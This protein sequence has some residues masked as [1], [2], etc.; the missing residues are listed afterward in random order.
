MPI[1]PECAADY[2]ASE[3][4]CR[5]DGATLLPTTDPM[6]GVTV[7]SYRLVK[8]LGEGGMGQVYLGVH[9]NI[10]SRVAVKL[11]APHATR[12]QELV[13]R[14]F[15]E[16]MAVNRIRHE[17]IVNVLDFNAVTL[18]DGSSRPYLVM[19]HLDGRPL[20]AVFAH[21]QRLPQ[22]TL[23]HLIGEVLGALSAAHHAGII[24]RDLKPDNIFV[25]PRGH[26][27]VLD[28]GIAKL[29]PNAAGDGARFTQ[30]GALLGT[31]SYMAPEQVRGEAV[32]AALDLYAVGII[33]FEGLTGS[34][35]F[36][37]E[38]LYALLNQHLTA[39]PPPMRTLTPTIDPRLEAVVLRALAKDP[40]QRF[41]SADAMAHALMAAV[42]QLPPSEWVSISLAG[43][44]PLL[45]NNPIV[46]S[47]PSPMRPD[48]H[49]R[50]GAVDRGSSSRR[51]GIAALAIAGV[52]SI[53]V[54]GLWL[55]R[56]SWVNQGERTASMP[57]VNAPKAEEELR[58]I[59]AMNSNDSIARTETESAESNAGGPS[60]VESSTPQAD[61]EPIELSDE[62]EPPASSET[63]KTPSSGTRSR[64]SDDGRST[65]GRR[66]TPRSDSN[67]T[68]AAA[69]PS[70]P[71]ATKDETKPHS[72]S[73][74]QIVSTAEIAKAEG[75][76][77]ITQAAGVD[78]RRFNAVGY[79]A[80]AKELARRLMSDAQLVE[81]EVSGVKANGVADL[82]QR[83]AEASFWFRSKSRSKPDPALPQGVSPDDIY[84]MVYVDVQGGEAHAYATT[85]E[86]CNDGFERPPRCS[87]AQVWTKAYAMG[88]PRGNWV[89]KLTYNG[90][91]W[92]FDIENGAGDGDDFVATIPD[93]C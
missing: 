48:V 20:S 22:G 80:K 12:N 10:G 8:L 21:F 34:L 28:F 47:T 33:L 50:V 11:I 65:S 63:M 9:P 5:T 23:V 15:A 25:S 41:G 32:T 30:T 16:A 35:P 2:P 87:L 93:N 86:R 71:E 76:K 57:T 29:L 70:E 62:D 45:T 74:V 17:N 24:H 73:G 4:F 53:S 77:P 56:P 84:C 52:A 61:D 68:R 85:R 26:A 55:G 6:I 27:K 83:Y 46:R 69:K 82:N 51:V 49:D 91:E 72:S 54:A 88:A 58:T 90:G 89:A 66:V 75:F 3:R 40:A 67:A 42:E 79:I 7:G 59:G 1:C 14:F 37:G 43:D 38:T 39:T 60:T 92:F 36:R 44:V 31:P 19:E 78:T 64:S 81:F 18:P 13:D